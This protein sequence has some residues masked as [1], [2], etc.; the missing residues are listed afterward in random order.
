MTK[1]RWGIIGAG[2][3]AQTFARGVAASSSGEVV[4]VGSRTEEAA[5]TFAAEFGVARAHGSYQAVL[6]DPDVDA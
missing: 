5:R 1:L 6:D 4:A 3:I 2:T